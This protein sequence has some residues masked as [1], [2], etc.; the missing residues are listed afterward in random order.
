MPDFVS[1]CSA[2]SF[3][4]DFV[5]APALAVGFFVDDFEDSYAMGS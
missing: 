3:A 4:V 2:A 5:D 1:P